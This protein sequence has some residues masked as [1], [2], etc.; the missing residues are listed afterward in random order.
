[1][2]TPELCA[3]KPRMVGRI[4]DLP[5]VNDE[6]DETDEIDRHGDGVQPGELLRRDGL[7]LRLAAIPDL[8]EGFYLRR[9]HVAAQKS[10]RENSNQKRKGKTAEWFARINCVRKKVSDS[11]EAAN[12]IEREISADEVLGDEAGI[13]VAKNLLH[14]WAKNPTSDTKQEKESRPQPNGGVE[15]SNDAQH[16]EHGE[17]LSARRAQAKRRSSLDYT[18]VR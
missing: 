17:K 12:E 2:S 7:L 5:G 9:E 10:E 8:V 18:V 6:G 16:N 4:G 15:H 1:M 11:D 14:L 13:I 3:E